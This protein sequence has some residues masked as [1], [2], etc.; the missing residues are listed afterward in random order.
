M[1][2]QPWDLNQTWPVDRKWCWFTNAPE[3][4]RGFDLKCGAQ[5][6]SKFLTTFSRLSRSTPHISG[7]KRRIDKQKC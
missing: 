7:M 6:N 3:K 5:K 4:F 2:D 1:K